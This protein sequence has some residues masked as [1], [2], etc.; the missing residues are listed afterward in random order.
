VTER[1]KDL[2]ILNMRERTIASGFPQ[3][4]KGGPVTRYLTIVDEVC[5]LDDGPLSD[6]CKEQTNYPT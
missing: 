3:I 5:G 1:K 2:G 6:F 4:L